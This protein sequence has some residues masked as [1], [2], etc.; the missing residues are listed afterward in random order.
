M[1]AYMKHAINSGNPVLVKYL[2]NCGAGVNKTFGKHD[3]YES[4]TSGMMLVLIIQEL[5]SL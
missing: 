3:T 1:C 4:Y 2:L 5:I